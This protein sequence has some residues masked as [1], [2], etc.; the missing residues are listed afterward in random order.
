MTKRILAVLLAAVMLLALVTGCSKDSADQTTAETSSEPAAAVQPEIEPSG[1]TDAQSDPGKIEYP[2]GDGSQTVS[3]WAAFG[4]SEYLDSY[5]ELSILAPLKEATGV[6]LIFVESSQAAASEQ[7]NLMVASGE[8]ADMLPVETYYSGGLAQAFEDEVIIDLTE[9]IPTNAP[10]YYRLYEGLN[11]RSK[12]SVLTNNMHLGVFTIN[13]TV[14]SDRG[15]VIRGDWLDEL[16]LEVP[17][18]KDQLNDVM[19]AFHDAYGCTD[20]YAVGSDGLMYS[21]EAAMDS[22]LPGIGTLSGFYTYIDDQ[23]RVASGFN[24][25]GYREYVQWFAQLYSDGIIN[26]DFYTT[27][28]ST[29]TTLGMAGSGQTGIFSCGCDQL[30]QVLDYIEDGSSFTLTPV[31]IILPGEGAENTWVEESSLVSSSY[32]ITA[33]C[34]DPAFVLNYLNYYY[35]DE[36]Y[37]YANY[38]VQGET[39]EYDADGVPQY[40]DFMLN[41]PDGI[42][43]G[44]C[45]Q[46]YC[47]NVTPYLMCMTKMAVT[48]NDEQKNAAAVWAAEGTDEHTYPSGA[49]LTSEEQAEITDKITSISSFS[50]EQVLKFMTGQEA[51]TDASWDAYCQELENLGFSDCLAMYQ[52]AYEEYLAGERIVINS[53]GGAGGGS[54]GEPPPK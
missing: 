41:N 29:N 38:G 27:T 20:T 8:W 49:G 6:E 28:S 26:K 48:W 17:T 1:E 45:S 7:F 3:A 37:L 13:D 15:L 46:I 51:L 34:E 25:D 50:Q 33:S 32:S 23:G 47:L 14:N 36:G 31:K 39:W 40:N 4:L 12:E 9:L 22:T 18:T 19:Y 2:I 16:G 24:S 21:M 43:V 35:T 10:D 30:T 42:S 53:S 54:E 11:R 5:N 52:N 44:A